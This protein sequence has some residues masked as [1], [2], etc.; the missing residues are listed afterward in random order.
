[1]EKAARDLHAKGAACVVITGGHMA[2]LKDHGQGATDGKEIVDVLFDGGRTV[3]LRGPKLEA[4]NSHGTGCTFASAIAA[5]LA[6][7]YG[8]RTAV[9]LARQYVQG[10][11]E[12]S[13]GLL[14][15]GGMQRP[16]NHGYQTHNWAEDR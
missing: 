9:Q 7:G 13:S 2:G 16:M 12:A 6:K 3:L 1:M 14:V 8:V 11:L 4:A 5:H 15:G 10:A